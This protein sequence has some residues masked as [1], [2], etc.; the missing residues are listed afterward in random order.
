YLTAEVRADA[1]IATR[2]TLNEK[3]AARGEKLSLNDLLIRACASALR[4]VP[5]VNASFMSDSIWLHQVIDISVAVALPEGLVTPVLRDAD[6]KGL[7]EISREVRELANSARQKKLKPEQMS[8][9]TFSISNLGMYGI[10]EFQA[11]IN[12]PEGAILAVG[13]IRE[14]PTFSDGAVRPE[15]RIRLTL[16]CD[17]RVIDGA[18]GAQWLAA[19][20]ELVE[21]P[22]E[23]LL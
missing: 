15:N 11:V 8:G 4:R 2:Q 22:L 14:V 18:V 16:S 3:L 13:A 1:L 23:L 12:P 6:K 7:L 17:H 19:L 10:D 5:A 9:G 20:R 21:S